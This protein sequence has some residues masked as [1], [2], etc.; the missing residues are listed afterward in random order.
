MKNLKK[1]ILAALVVLVLALFGTMSIAPTASALT[2]SIPFVPVQDAEDADLLRQVLSDIGVEPNEDDLTMNLLRNFEPIGSVEIQGLLESRSNVRF[3]V[4]LQS[5]QRCTGDYCETLLITG[6]KDAG[7]EIAY[8][9]FADGWGTP[10]EYSGHW[11]VIDGETA[12]H[13]MFKTQ[14]GDCS[15][16]F[17]ATRVIE[18][19]YLQ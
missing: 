13:W 3:F 6:S 1:H 8:R 12:F 4:Q 17:T 16:F 14:D 2:V 5:P 10:Q 15:Y 11:Y 9:I 18:F 7:Y 19:C